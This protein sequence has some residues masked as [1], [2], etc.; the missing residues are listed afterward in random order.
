MYSFLSKLAA[1][2]GQK[3]L[4]AGLIVAVGVAAY[5]GWLF[6]QEQGHAELRRERALQELSVRQDQLFALK[7]AIEKRVAEFTAEISAQQQRAQK[8]RAVI[9]ALRTLESWWD[10][11][12]SNPEQQ[13]ANADQIKRMEELD[14]EALR[15]VNEL[16][17]LVAKTKGE[18]E[19]LEID[20]AGVQRELGA[21]ERSKSTVLIYLRAAWEQTKWYVALALGAYFF[22]PTLWALVMYYGF[23]SFIA[24]GR[25]IRFVRELSAFP[26]VGDSH[27]SVEVVLGGIEVLRIKEKYLQASDEGLQKKTRFVLDWRIPFTSVACGLTELVEM[28]RQDPA[29]ESRVTLSNSVDPHIELAV[30]TLP[31]GSSVILRPSFLGGVIQPDDHPL[32]IRRHWQLLRWQSWVTG[33]FRFFEF[34]GPCRLI[35]AGSRGVRAEEMMVEGS[36]AAQARRTNQ[37][38]T[39][40]FTPNL[41]YRPV[42]AETFWGYYRGM[43]PL[44]DDLFAGRGVFILQETAT[45]GSAAKSGRFWSALWNGVLKVFGL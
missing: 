37:D 7:T 30:V 33:Q 31:P 40:G 38:A 34:V 5:G 35:V 21:V 41:S 45:P 9:A 29:G 39:I 16:R 1:W 44:F 14:S 6:L 36:P 15:R 4:V 25:P 24:R 23:A 3:L 32:Q 8:A 10:R 18:M 20:L 2:L 27:V 28:R 42:R 11:L 43:N 26:V 12:F 19:R 22:G 13:K 17:Q